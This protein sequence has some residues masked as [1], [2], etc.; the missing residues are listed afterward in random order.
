MDNHKKGLLLVFIAA[1]LWSTGGVFIK[2]ISLNT[3]QLS[4]F[5]SLLAAATLLVIF[6]KEALIFN[7]MTFFNAMFYAEVLILFVL[8]AKT[9]TVANAIFLQYT[10]PIFVFIFEPLILKTKFEKSN[11]ITIIIAVIGM[12]LFFSGELSPGDI[13][14]NIIAILSGMAF[15][16]FL[17]GMRKNEPKY[18]FPTIFYGNVLISLICSFSLFK[19]ETVSTGDMIMVTYMGIFQIGIAYIIFSY[20]L[21][22]V[23]AT[24]ASLISMIEP[25]LNP[26][27]TFLGYGEV[28]SINSIIGGIIIL[29]GLSYKTIRGTER[30]SGIKN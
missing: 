12:V 8:A 23:S 27:W 7:R 29:A 4:F 24:E 16:A 15:A 11:L 19:L 10:A 17:I 1:L 9:T 25:V 26:V 14:G 3:F 28:P 13:N 22:K 6:R 18:Q 2:L 5:R 21:K 30:R 20:G